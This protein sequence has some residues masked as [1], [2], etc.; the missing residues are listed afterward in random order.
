MFF[1]VLDF[2]KLCLNNEMNFFIN[3]KSYLIGFLFEDKIYFMDNW[4]LWRSVFFFYVEFFRLCFYLVIFGF[5][6]FYKGN[7]C[8]RYR[9]CYRNGRCVNGDCC[10]KKGYIGDGVRLCYSKNDFWNFFKNVFFL[11][12]I[13]IKNL[14]RFKCFIK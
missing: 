1:F 10:C 9:K 13:N 8:G 6:L 4:S 5:F 2:F 14:I 7:R 3:M 11:Y 12:I